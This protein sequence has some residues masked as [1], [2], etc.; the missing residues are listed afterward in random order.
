MPIR[1]NVFRCETH[2]HKW[3]RVQGMKP[4][5]GG[6]CEYLKP[7]LEKQTNTKLAPHETIKKVLKCRCLKCPLK[8]HLD[9]IC[10]SYDQ[11]KGWEPNWEFDS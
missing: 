5:D 2:F 9:L 3:G 6:S 1:L 4:N 10:I 7:W 8:V 11:K